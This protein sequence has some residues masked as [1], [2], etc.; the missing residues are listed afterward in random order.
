METIISPEAFAHL[1]SLHADFAGTCVTIGNFDGVHVGHQHLL[2]RTRNKAQEQGLLS[3]VVTFWPHPLQVLA[4][5]RAPTL[6]M[7]Q[8][9]RLQYIEQHAIDIT[10]EMP[11]TLPLASLSPEDFVR[12]VLAPLCCKE[13]IIGYDFSLGKGRAGNFDVLCDLG[14]TYGFRVEQ[15]SPVIVHDAVVSSTRIRNHIRAGEMWDARILLG[16]AYAIEGRVVHGHGRGKGLGFPT[17]NLQSDAALIPRHGV[18]ATFIS[19]QSNPSVHLSAVTNIGLVPTFGNN[20]MSIESFILDG[21]EEYEKDNEGKA[22]T[23]I[24][25]YD[26]HITLAFVQGIREERH[27]ANVQDLQKRIERDIE[28]AQNIL[29]KSLKKLHCFF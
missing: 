17:A 25:L 15:L 9:R 2:Q 24:D 21:L 13:L 20:S 22:C 7:S 8:E 14:R 10:L 12:T 18:Y 11:F 27:F 16:R 19:L 6:L 26:E 5:M 1:D 29:D 23:E 3:V 28:L 4:G